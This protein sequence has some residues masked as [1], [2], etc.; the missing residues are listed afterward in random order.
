MLHAASC[1][2]SCRTSPLVLPPAT[3]TNTLLHNTDEERHLYTLYGIDDAFQ[4]SLSWSGHVG[5][6]EAVLT[7]ASMHNSLVDLIAV[8]IAWRPTRADR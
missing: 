7:Q 3:H 2:T 1:N 5:V 6:I 8:L 4:L